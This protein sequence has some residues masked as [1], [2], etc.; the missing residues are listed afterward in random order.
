MDQYCWDGGIRGI[1]ESLAHN[2]YILRTSK[3]RGR[4]GCMFVELH[5]LRDLTTEL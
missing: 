2:D 4:C 3:R 1:I 5:K